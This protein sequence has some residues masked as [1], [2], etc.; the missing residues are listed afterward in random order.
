MTFVSI[1]YNKTPRERIKL[2]QS[3][4]NRLHVSGASITNW[5]KGKIP[6]IVH[7][8]GISAILKTPVDELFPD[9]NSDTIVKKPK[10]LEDVEPEKL[11]EALEHL[12]LGV[13][14]HCQDKNILIIF[15]HNISAQIVNIIQGTN[16]KDDKEAELALEQ[17]KK[18]FTL[19]KMFKLDKQMM[20]ILNAM[21][22]LYPD[23]KSLSIILHKAMTRIVELS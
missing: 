22:P 11:K 1:Y 14:E 6:N 19:T 17:I 9:N 12:F 8:S 20:E 7:R 15:A 18:Q 3:L 23:D 10:R 16:I 4:I 2:K 21:L 5:L 13:I